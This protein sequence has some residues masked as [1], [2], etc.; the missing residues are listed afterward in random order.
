L[1]P[2]TRLWFFAHAVR[3]IGADH[4]A[5]PSPICVVE[6]LG[7][8][9]GW[10]AASTAL[11]RHRDNDPPHLIYLPEERISES[12]LLA[13]VESVYRRLGRV[14]VVVCEGQ[15]D[16]RGL[17]FGAQVDRPESATHNLASNLGHTLAQRIAAGLGVR[18]RAEKPGL[19][20]RSC[21]ALASETDREESYACGKRAVEFARQ[22]ASAV[23]IACERMSNSDY[24]IAWQP[25]P[26]TGVAGLE[27]PFP[28]HWFDSS[29]RENGFVL[30]AFLDWLKPLAGKVLPSPEPL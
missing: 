11:A 18:A 24:K 14:L 5:L 15:R 17:V 25:V 20:G 4:R 28:S 26:L 23:M 6:T 13:D 30:Q 3:D 7:R 9:T 1:R 2:H 29:L 21:Q 8:N 27:K 12:Q 16:D 22:G 19:L 10:I